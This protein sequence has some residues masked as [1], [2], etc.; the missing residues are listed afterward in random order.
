MGPAYFNDILEFPRFGGQG[1]AQT[2]DRWDQALVYFFDSGDMHGRGE[3]VIGRLGLVD[4]IVGVD[5]CLTPS[6]REPIGHLAAGHLDRA[7][8]NNLID[9]HVGL[10]ATSCLP[11]RKREMA[12]ELVVND[13]LRGAD[14]KR[15]L[16]LGQQAQ[17][18]VG[19]GRRFFDD[20]QRADQDRL[21][22][23]CSDLKVDQRPRRLGAVIFIRRDIDLP[24]TIGFNTIGHGYLGSFLSGT[25]TGTTPAN[26]PM[27]LT[28]SALEGITIFALFCKACST[29][30]NFLKIWA[31]PTKY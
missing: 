15:R 26:S 13:L 7:V 20:P 10:G 5:E 3:N 16:F 31:L 29:A 19:L 17:F 1:V 23:F 18:H 30:S 25:L 4:V 22:M 28:N 21:E 2:C 6:Q 8:G 12:A 24:H 11:D 27:T 9:V 14:D